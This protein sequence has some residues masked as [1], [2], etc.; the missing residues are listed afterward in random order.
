ME[1]ESDRKYTEDIHIRN[2]YAE[3]FNP[4]VRAL[5]VMLQYF[6]REYFAK[7]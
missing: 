1:K 5:L 3:V 6:E 2:Y 4:N 7:Q